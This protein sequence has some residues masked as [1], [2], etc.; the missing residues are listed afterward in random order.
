MKYITFQSVQ[1]TALVYLLRHNEQSPHFISDWILNSREPMWLNHTKGFL[2]KRHF[3]AISLQ[4]EIQGDCTLNVQCNYLFSHDLTS[5]GF[6]LLE[7]E[8][9]KWTGKAKTNGLHFLSLKSYENISQTTRLLH[10]MNNSDCV[11][12]RCLLCGW[13]GILTCF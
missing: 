7:L 9:R 10:F 2:L 6:S 8:I 3:P 12:E 5:S 4:G 11:P 1:G 13:Q